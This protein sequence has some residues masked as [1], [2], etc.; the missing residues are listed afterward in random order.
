MPGSKEKE[1]KPILFQQRDQLFLLDL[2]DH[3][4]LDVEYLEKHI[5]KNSSKP[6]IY[7]RC[8]ALQA[9]GYIQIF[10]IPVV[11]TNKG[12]SKNVYAL[13]KRGANE[14]KTL[15]GEEVGWRYD[16]VNRT[17]TTINH[18][19]ELGLIR[20]AFQDDRELSLEER[21]PV[22]ENFEMV[23][24]LN[25]KNGYHKHEVNATNLVIRPDGVLVLQNKA[26]G[27]CAPFFLEL[28]R[29]YQLKKTT[30]EKLERYN[31]YCKLQLFKEEHRSFNYPVGTPRILFIAKDLKGIDRLIKHSKGVDVSS[32]NG[33]MYTTFEQITN[34]PYGKI[35]YALGSTD[36]EKLYSLISKI[37]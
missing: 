10:R 4:F 20:G 24:Y 23:Q 34:D 17:P 13:D 27:K 16:L 14:V 36:P 33:V 29:S 12:Q 3:Q 26:S 32:T 30:M 18:Q 28:E 22:N 5:Y 8:N 15:L 9:E 31:E 6:Y 11:G 37:E 19:L 25:E 1:T 35:F 2:W 7:R 21:I